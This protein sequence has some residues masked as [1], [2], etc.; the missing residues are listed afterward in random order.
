MGPVEPVI[1]ACDDTTMQHWRPRVCDSFQDERS[2]AKADSESDG[3]FNFGRRRSS[4][5][6]FDE[7]PRRASKADAERVSR[8]SFRLGSSVHWTVRSGSQASSL[9]LEGADADQT[10][11]STLDLCFGSYRPWHF[12]LPIQLE[13]SFFFLGP[14]VWVHYYHRITISD[15]PTRAPAEMAENRVI[16][17][18]TSSPALVLHELQSLLTFRLPSTTVGHVSHIACTSACTAD[19]PPP[20]SK[21]RSPEHRS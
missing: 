10:D 7:L 14:C 3:K 21:P 2:R 17:H 18:T 13:F 15:P 5:T 4:Y 16:K 1:K 6:N 12:M 8:H 11:L 9:T 20:P 19:D